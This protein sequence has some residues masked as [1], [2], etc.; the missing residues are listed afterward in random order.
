MSLF[1]TNRLLYLYT[2]WKTKKKTQRLTF[3]SERQIDLSVPQMHS[4][5]ATSKD[6]IIRSC[7]VH[8]VQDVEPL[9][10][11]VI[12]AFKQ[13]RKTSMLSQVDEVYHDSIM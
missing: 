2:K 7:R 6:W 9:S 4:I 5:K 12:S 8:R 3:K 10:P 11:M 1:D 13:V